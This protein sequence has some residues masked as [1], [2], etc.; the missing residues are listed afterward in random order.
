MAR[1][2]TMQVVRLQDLIGRELTVRD[3]VSG[4]QRD[5]QTNRVVGLDGKLDIRPAYQ[6]EFVYNERQSEAVI[7]TVYRGFPLNTMYWVENVDPETG[8]TTYEVLDGQQR[9][10]SICDYIVGQDGKGNG[11]SVIFEGNNLP[12]TFATLQEDEKNLILDYPLE[13]YVCRGTDSEKLRWFY[14]INTVGVKLT[15]QELRNSTYHGPFVEAAKAIFSKESGRGIILAEHA[16][17]LPGGKSQKLLA[18]SGDHAWLR[19][20]YLETALSWVANRDGISIEEYM[21]RHKNDKDASDLWQYFVHVITWVHSTFKVYRPQMKGL[22][23]GAWYER[24]NDTNANVPIRGMSSDDIEQWIQRLLTDDEVQSTRGI[25]EYLLDGDGK[26]LSLR[27][28]DERTAM[29]VYEA[30]QHLCPVCVQEGKYDPYSFDEMQADHIMPWSKGGKTE[31][32]NCN[33]E[34]GNRW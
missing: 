29:K 33:Q 15:T 22:P 28:F 30:Q 14:V 31:D 4:Y 8:E 20:G 2:L 21:S 19:Q 17:G 24:Y 34:K 13:V 3:L 11:F 16:D 9:S 5:E 1:E 26:H 27:A 12:K 25:Y 23:W 7:Q 6:R 18:D 10:I 32:S